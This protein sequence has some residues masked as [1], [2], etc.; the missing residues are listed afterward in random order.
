MVDSIPYLVI[1][2]LG[3]IIY[4]IYLWSKIIS[5][6]DKYVYESALSDLKYANLEIEYVELSK[7][8]AE[9]S[10]K[11]DELLADNMTNYNIAIS[12]AEDIANNALSDAISKMD[13]S[14]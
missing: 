7:K 2:G 3:V 10:K 8:Y 13:E 6:N 5:A 4:I 9:L 11:Y 14:K 12:L 1:A